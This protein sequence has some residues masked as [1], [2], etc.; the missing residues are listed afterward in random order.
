MMLCLSL[1]ITEALVSMSLSPC[2]SLL[3]DHLV[4]LLE[5]RC[6]KL[7]NLLAGGGDLPFGFLAQRLL[8]IQRLEKIF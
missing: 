8:T 7:L 2:S 3:G 4:G 6:A 5:E 1:L